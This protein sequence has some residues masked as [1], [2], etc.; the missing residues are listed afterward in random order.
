MENWMTV[1]QINALGKTTSTG[2]TTR[3]MH[4]Y[5]CEHGILSYIAT[6]R[7]QDCDDAYAI[8]TQN[9]MHIDAALTVVT[10]LEGYFSALPTKRL[11]RYIEKIKPDVV[12]LRILHNFYINLHML[13]EFLSRKNIPTVITLH[14]MWFLTGKCCFY[15][16]F[17]CDKWQTGC[18]H[19]PAMIEDTRK[20]WFDRSERMWND[21]RRLLTNIP[22]LAVIGNSQWT[23]NEVRKSFLKDALVLDCVYNWIDF[24]VFYPRNPEEIRTK[25][26]LEGKK[27]ILAVSVSWS[28]HNRKGFDNYLALSSVIPE[29][30]QIVLVGKMAYEGKLPANMTVLPK[31]DKAEELAMYYSLADVYLN[32]SAGET[33]GKVSAEALSCGTPVIGYNNTANPEMVPPNGGVVIDSVDSEVVL[34]ALAQVFSKPKAAYESVCVNYAHNLFDM[35]TNIEKYIDIYKKLIN[36]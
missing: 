9:A 29:N 7:N 22:R 5:F 34:E 24:S 16:H 4:D 25:L 19:C 1:L 3:E 35:Q 20:R 23:T 18:N 15:N 2:R 17:P 12:H 13:M 33:F 21:K 8:S 27:V 32:L 6:A 11:I 14:D 30:Y 31:T 26:K 36:S 28:E 10:G